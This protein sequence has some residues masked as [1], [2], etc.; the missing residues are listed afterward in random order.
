MHEKW[1]KEQDDLLN[2]PVHYEN[3]KFDEIRNLGTGY[4][5]FSKDEEERKKQMEGLK[6]MREETKNCLLYTSPSPRDRG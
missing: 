5:A 1:R 6:N 4:Y 2:G 3:L